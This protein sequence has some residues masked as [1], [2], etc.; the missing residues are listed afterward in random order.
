MCKWD[1]QYDP[2]CR[3]IADILTLSYECIFQAKGT[4]RT[5]S[6]IG[7]LTLLGIYSYRNSYDS[8]ASSQLGSNTNKVFYRIEKTSFY[9]FKNGG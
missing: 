3:S 5:F 7:I 9:E 2:L 6:S 1:V 8:M 4:R